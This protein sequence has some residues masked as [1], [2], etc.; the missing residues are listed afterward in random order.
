VNYLLKKFAILFFSIACV[1]FHPYGSI[2]KFRSGTIK[3]V[4]QA[5]LETIVA[6]SEK[7]NG[8]LD[9]TTREFAFFVLNNSFHGFNN[10]LQQEHFNE[11]YIESEKYPRSTFTG[12]IVEDIPFTKAGSYEVRA[13]GMLNVHGVDQERIIKCIVNIA[14]DGI[15]ISSSFSVLLSDHDISVPKIVFDKIAPEVQVTVNLNMEEKKDG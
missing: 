7:I 6:T 1:S 14:P 3:F 2:Y 10:I 13:K 15:H 12:K 5:P 9:T 4:S 8:L 11:S